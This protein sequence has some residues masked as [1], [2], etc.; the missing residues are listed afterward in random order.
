MDTV[1]GTLSKISPKS[2][3]TFVFRSSVKHATN[4]YIYNIQ[5]SCRRF[6]KNLYDICP[7]NILFKS[8]LA[9]VL[10]GSTVGFPQ[11]NCTRILSQNVDEKLMKLLPRMT[12]SIMP[13][14]VKLSRERS[15]S[16]NTVILLFTCLLVLGIVS[17]IPKK[18]SERNYF[19]LIYLNIFFRKFY[20]FLPK[21]SF[22]FN[23]L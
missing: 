10:P 22:L 8:W 2:S 15:F 20:L 16:W 14:I 23:C 7:Y 12:K 1:I 9:R 6:A 18:Y 17:R 13:K 5:I 3:T 19:S 11:R 21:I 4:N